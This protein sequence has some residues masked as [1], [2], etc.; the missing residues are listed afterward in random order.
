MK[1]CI[2]SEKRINMTLRQPNNSI[3]II[4]VHFEITLC[5]QEKGGGDHMTIRKLEVSSPPPLGQGKEEGEDSGSSHN[6]S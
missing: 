6:E 2:S 4:L 1:R 3:S 5:Y